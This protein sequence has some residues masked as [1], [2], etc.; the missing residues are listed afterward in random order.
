MIHYVNIL[1]RLG[2]NSLLVKKSIVA[3]LYLEEDR[4]ITTKEKIL[5]LGAFLLYPIYFLL[6]LKKNNSES[7]ILRAGELTRKEYEMR[8]YFINKYSK[9]EV[10]YDHIDGQII[11]YKGISVRKLFLVGKVWFNFFVTLISILGIKKDK[12][13]LKAYFLVFNTVVSLILLNKQGKKIH[14]FQIFDV[15][16]YLP[17]MLSDWYPELELKLITSSSILYA[18]NRYC[19]TPASEIIYCSDYQKF[20]IQTFID[21]NWFVIKN[22]KLWGL[23]EA[24]Q[25][26]LLEPKDPVYEIALYSSGEWARRDGIFRV[27]DIEAIQRGDFLENELYQQFE[28]I[29]V[30]LSKVIKQNGL[31]LAVYLHPYEKSLYREHQLVPPFISLLEKSIGKQFEVDFDNENSIS[32]IYESR[33]AVSLLSTSISD[34][35]HL[36]LEGVMFENNETTNFRKIIGNYG[37]FVFSTMDEFVLFMENR[38]S[39]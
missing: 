24:N 18:S 14:V 25:Y 3:R 5:I 6:K 23:E 32:K 11:W 1:K 37:N 4:I 28:Q 35:W 26:D 2:F 27:N 9:A 19:F 17:A 8:K 29:V 20:E 30:E 33:L 38:I 7:L 13:N 22:Y 36:G 12:H 31:T 39:K 15:R 10:D 16:N 34:R 21:R